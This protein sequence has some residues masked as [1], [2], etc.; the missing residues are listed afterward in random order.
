MCMIENLVEFASKKKEKPE[1]N[2]KKNWIELTSNYDIALL[3]R[4]IE[5]LPHMVVI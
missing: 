4:P 1:Q 3:T 5:E 2:W